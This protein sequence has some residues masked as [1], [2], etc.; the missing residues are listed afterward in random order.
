MYTF[1]FKVCF[2]V[3]ILQLYLKSSIELSRFLFLKYG[4]FAFVIIE[5]QLLTKFWSSAD[6]L[7]FFWKK[8]IAN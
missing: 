8:K 5:G 7:A 6:C 2:D 1:S 4:H 3:S